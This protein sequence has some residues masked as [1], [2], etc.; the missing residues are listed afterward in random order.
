VPPFVPRRRGG[1][2]DV[3]CFDPCFVEAGVEFD[4][5]GSGAGV[6]TG[7]EQNL[8]NFSYVMSTD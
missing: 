3:S 6:M 2:E 1:E 4:A 7:V 8:S 5:L